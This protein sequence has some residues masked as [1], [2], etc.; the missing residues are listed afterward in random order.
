MRKQFMSFLMLGAFF[1]PPAYS[2]D[3]GTITIAF[4]PNYNYT[5]KAAFS[6]R[7]NTDPAYDSAYVYTAY[8]SGEYVTI[9]ALKG[10]AV[11][12][13]RVYSTDANYA[14]AKRI[15]LGFANGYTIYA[16]SLAPNSRC[17]SLEMRFDTL[18][19]GVVQQ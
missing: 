4:D 12:Y 1:A 9:S 2:D 17:D 13:C 3:P 6:V 15:A 5:L 8:V 16:K 7:Y 14:E 18:E 11:F 10:Y 19:L